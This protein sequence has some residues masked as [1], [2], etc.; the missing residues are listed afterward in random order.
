MKTALALLALLLLA[1]AP[2]ANAQGVN[3]TVTPYVNPDGTI[4]M[5][6]G[7]AWTFRSFAPRVYT[8]NTYRPNPF[9]PS[10]FALPTTRTTTLNTQ[11]QAWN[12]YPLNVGG[13]T[14]HVR[15]FGRQQV[16]FLGSL[17]FV[18]GLFRNQ[19]NTERL[20]TSTLTVRPT[21]IDP[22]GNP[23]PATAPLYYYV[24]PPAGLIE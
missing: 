1:T 7:G 18:G 14:T 17:P 12:G 21:L 22:A 6:L 13:A 9:A 20:N 16:P 3:F 10:P 11:V 23:L 15:T 2:G 5:N 4:E 24:P 19:W 8:P